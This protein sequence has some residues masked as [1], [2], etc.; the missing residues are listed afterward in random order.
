MTGKRAT[1]KQFN[2]LLHN[3]LDEL[4]A[5]V[6]PVFISTQH[7]EVSPGMVWW[8]RHIPPAQ[9]LPREETILNLFGGKFFDDSTI[10]K[11]WQ[12]GEYT[13]AQKVWVIDQFVRYENPIV[14]PDEAKFSWIQS[15]PYAETSEILRD[16]Q[17]RN[18]PWSSLSEELKFQSFKFLIRFHHPEP[19]LKEFNAMVQNDFPNTRKIV[20]DQLAHILPLIIDLP[21]KLFWIQKIPKFQRTMADKGYMNAY[22]YGAFDQ[23]G[24]VMNRRY[25]SAR[26]FS[27]RSLILKALMAD[28]DLPEEATWLWKFEKEMKATFGP[29]EYINIQASMTNLQGWITAYFHFNFGHLTA[30]QKSWGLKEMSQLRSPE[31]IH[32]FQ[33]L[34]VQIALRQQEAIGK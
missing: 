25:P 15:R 11:D 32:A 9:L 31:G 22:G 19:T 1:L 4:L 13:E 8:L 34:T 30:M 5:K 26:R 10:Q 16:W 3:N 21:E 12:F 7:Y 20:E 29:A 27:E 18:I 23:Y 33:E 2:V 6:R 28:R 24:T 14:F 17:L